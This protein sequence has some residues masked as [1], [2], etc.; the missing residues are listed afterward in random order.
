MWKTEI[1]TS[2]AFGIEAAS[3]DFNDYQAPLSKIRRCHIKNLILESR[4][5]IYRVKKARHL[6]LVKTPKLMSLSKLSH[7]SL[8]SNY[9]QKG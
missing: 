8:H 9:V 2:I 7:T 6:Q 1:T 5:G 4:P 3:G